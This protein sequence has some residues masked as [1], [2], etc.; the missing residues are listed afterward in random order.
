MDDWMLML[1]LSTL[2]VE[3]FRLLPAFHTR[4]L[5]ATAERLQT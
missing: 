1:P 5:F 2:A 3:M 4:K